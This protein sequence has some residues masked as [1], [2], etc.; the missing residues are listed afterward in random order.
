MAREMMPSRI[1]GGT[2]SVRSIMRVSASIAVL[3]LV[4]TVG[5]LCL[6]RVDNAEYAIVTEFGKPTQV[7]TL[8]GLGF[9]LPYQSVRTIDRRLFVYASPPTEFLTLEKTPVR[10][11]SGR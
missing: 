4:F 10:G 5:S 8:P 7:V 1:T 9:K 3:A 6:F 11:G 2:A